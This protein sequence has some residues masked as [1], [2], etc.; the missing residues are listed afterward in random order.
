MQK[1]KV[2]LEVGNYCNLKCPLCVRE[3]VDKKILNTIHLSLDTVKKFLPR[4]F[5]RYYVSDVYLSGAVAE[6]TLNPDF[7][8]I[9]K[10]L[11]LHSSV[12]IDSNGSTKNI[13]WWKELGKT[14]VQCTFAPDSIK[15]NNNKY[16]INSNTSKVIE[17]IKA[18][19]DAGGKSIWKFIPYSHNEDEIEDQKKIS[20]SIGSEFSF[21]QPRLIPKR[22]E[23][24]VN[25]TT[26]SLTKKDKY[27]VSYIDNNS[28]K[29]YCKLFGEIG[30]YLIEISPEG[31]V[32]PCCMMP[33][34]FY[35]VYK[36]FF[37]SDDPTPD[38]SI[39]NKEPKRISFI[40][41]VVPLIEKNGGI[42]SLSL[43]NHTIQEILKSPF[44]DSL[45]KKSWEDDCSFCNTFCDS[46]KYNLK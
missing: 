12:Y 46:S 13:E 20:N 2:R 29:H 21:V 6:P 33:R 23:E 17:N 45:L 36:N 30:D 44:Y 15:P 16:R 35:F 5:L 41:T 37:I 27:Q 1:W 7:I 10:Y 25:F 32:Y 18:F 26:S 11:M 39:E 38:L 42:Q 22:L 3:I 40:K 19:T 8:D 14:G 4:T 43:H 28:P 9:I 24:N 31:I 34:D